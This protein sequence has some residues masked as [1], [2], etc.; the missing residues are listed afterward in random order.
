MRGR[1]TTHC[2][3][4]AVRVYYAFLRRDYACIGKKFHVEGDRVQHDGESM[5]EG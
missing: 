4:A 1:S 3:P 2:V 5:E